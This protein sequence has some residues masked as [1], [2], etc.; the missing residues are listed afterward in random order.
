VQAKYN[1]LFEGSRNMGV[2]H[3]N[4]GILFAF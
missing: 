4:A 3:L 1:L 2:F